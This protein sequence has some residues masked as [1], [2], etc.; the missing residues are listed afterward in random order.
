M[1]KAQVAANPSAILVANWAGHD[2]HSVGLIAVILYHVY[3]DVKGDYW[4]ILMLRESQYRY[5]I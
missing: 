2:A 3:T 5:R 1:G 4:A